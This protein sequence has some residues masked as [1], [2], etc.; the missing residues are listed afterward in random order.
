MM[1]DDI[2]EDAPNISDRPALAAIQYLL[3]YG[4]LPDGLPEAVKNDPELLTVIDQLESLQQFALALANGNLEADFK[5]KGRV[6]G[7]LKTL[8]SNLRHLTWQVQRVASGDLS[9]RVRFLGEFATAFNTMVENLRQSRQELESRAKELSDG[10][11][12]A[13]NLMLD[14]E[15]AY[16]KLQAQMEEIKT[17]QAQLREQAIRD[18]LTTCF[19]RRYLDETIEREFARAG[20][21]AYPISLLMVDIDQFKKVNDTY[22]HPAGDAVLMAIGQLLRHRTRAGDIICRYGG[23][24]FLM[25]LPNMELENATRRADGCRIDLMELEVPYGGIKVKITVSI[26]VASFSIHG[27]TPAQVIQTAD[28]ALYLAKNSGRNCVR[29]PE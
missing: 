21:E 26:G 29:T 12:A 8:Q 27:S 14:G 6:A 17:L 10:R 7:A 9:Q 19:N 16:E 20:R 2:Q 23:E 5:F 11:R 28:R 3:L 15:I 22:G 13:L 4:R 1:T 24:E 18:S 25:V